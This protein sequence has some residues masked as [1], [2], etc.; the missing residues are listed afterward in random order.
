[1]FLL[2][3]QARMHLS[4]AATMPGQRGR[5]GRVGQVPVTPVHQRSQDGLQLASCL[6]GQILRSPPLSR[7]LVAPSLENALI[8]KRVQPMRE[9]RPWR[10][11]GGEDVL[12]AAVAEHDLPQDE[13]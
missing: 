6:G 7:K 5:S 4:S 2:A 8:H 1:M 12:E 3:A 11:R 9:D 13:Q 10:T